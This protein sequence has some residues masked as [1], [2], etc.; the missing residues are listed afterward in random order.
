MIYFNLKT[1]AKKFKKKQFI[2]TLKFQIKIQEKTQT[3]NFSLSLFIPGN[4]RL[5]NIHY[6]KEKPKTNNIL[7]CKSCGGRGFHIR[8]HGGIF[9]IRN[10]LKPCLL[11]S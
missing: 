10:R 9:A 1:P 8:R 11:H 6:R 5:A 7:S 3:E 2:L 4:F